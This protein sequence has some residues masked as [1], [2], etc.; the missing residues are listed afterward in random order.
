MSQPF[1]EAQL[2]EAFFG[3]R[4]LLAEIV[5]VFMDNWPSQ[6]EE[7]RSAVA[8]RDPEAIRTSAHKIKGSVLN[9]RAKGAR[10][11]AKALEYAGNDGTL[12]DIDAQ[13]A[14]FEAELARVVDALQVFIA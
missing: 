1:D 10:D 6:L 2:L 12:D 7:V 13:L 14:A 9:F 11:A 8:A 5:G 3:E 4:E